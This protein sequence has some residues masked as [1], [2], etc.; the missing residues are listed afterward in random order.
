MAPQI[1][2]LPSS[3]L[4]LSVSEQPL[5]DEELIKLNI[6]LKD[7]IAGFAAEAKLKNLHIPLHA[8]H[9]HSRM[10]DR[11]VVLLKREF[12]KC[13]RQNFRPEEIRQTI[14]LSIKTYQSSLNQFELNTQ[15]YKTAKQEETNQNQDLKTRIGQ[16]F[17]QAMQCVPFEDIPFLMP[18]YPLSFPIP[19]QE[20]S[21]KDLL[22]YAQDTINGVMHNWENYSE[23]LVPSKQEELLGKIQNTER[24]WNCAMHQANERQE[25]AQEFISH[26]DKEIERMNVDLPCEFPVPVYDDLVGET[27]PGPFDIDMDI[28]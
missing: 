12:F 24:R 13:T 16:A 25:A 27:W 1:A 3:S 19:K 26:L 6:E 22:Q 18:L 28:D 2:P 4:P 20:S 10:I 23:Q 14:S 9:A 17:I 8:Q 21:T 5:S 15:I 7:A 11:Y